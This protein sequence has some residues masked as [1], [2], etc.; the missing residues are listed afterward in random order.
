ML[1]FKIKMLYRLTVLTQQRSTMQP[2]DIGRTV[3]RK[4]SIGGLS[5]CA[6]CA[7]HSK[8]WKNS[9]WFTVFH[10]SIWGAR[11]FVWGAK[12]TKVLPWRRVWILGRYMSKPKEKKM[13]L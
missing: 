5:V 8:N 3:A 12:P 4:F 9:N 2:H 11:S 7:W 13:D 6:G 10:V 1:G